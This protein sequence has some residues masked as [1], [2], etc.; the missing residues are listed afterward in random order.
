MLFSRFSDFLQV[1][2][3]LLCFLCLLIMPV[4]KVLVAS[5]LFD[6]KFSFLRLAIKKVF[7]LYTFCFHVIFILIPLLSLW[8][9][10]N[11]ML[12]IRFLSASYLPGWLLLITFVVCLPCI[13]KV[14]NCPFAGAI[15]DLTDSSSPPQRL[16]LI[17]ALLFNSP[18][19]PRI[20]VRGR[21][22]WL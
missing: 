11:L 18:Q 1:F 22:N 4:L 20:R 3:T 9:I 17:G 12:S 5:N 7:F 15:N 13:W 8:F 2:L 21:A 19:L 6:F 10:P 14:V 16:L